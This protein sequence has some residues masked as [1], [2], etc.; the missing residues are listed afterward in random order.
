MLSQRARIPDFLYRIFW[1][2]LDWLYPPICGGCEK[3]YVRLCR[4]CIETFQIIQEPVCEICGLK[5]A[6]AG[7]CQEC[8]ASVR[9]YQ[10]LRSYAR[11]EGPLRKAILRLKYQKDIALGEILARPLGEMVD[12]LGWSVD[13][14]V[15]VPGS[16][17]RYKIR[18][19]NQA[20]LLALPIALHIGKPYRSKI[21]CKKLD[22]LSQVGLT[23]VERWQNVLG[24]FAVSDRQ[25]ADKS[26]LIVDDIRTSGATMEAC[27][28]ALMDSGAR[29]VYG[30]TLAQA[31]VDRI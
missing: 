16:I 30:L 24:A 12:K 31:H 19:Y 20:A 5:R 3:P 29:Q 7:V 8:N 15:P 11:Y 21:L 10:A 25:V 13:L 1:A 22:N 4:S 9:S 17:A 2:S 14:V 18:G 28:K 26:V 6:S 27:A 23:H